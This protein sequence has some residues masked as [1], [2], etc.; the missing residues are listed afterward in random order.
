[1]L[2]K[3]FKFSINLILISIFSFGVLV[4]ISLLP[5]TGNLK[6]LTVMSGSMEP[7]IHVGSLVFVKPV[8]QYNIGD[9]VTRKTDDPGVTITHRI[10]SKEEVAGKSVFQTKGDANNAEDSE[11]T[12]QER[13][14]GKVFFNIPYLGFP[15]GYAKTTKGLI[16][17]IIIPAVIIVYEEIGKI[18]NELVAMRVRKKAEKE[19]PEQTTDKNNIVYPERRFVRAV[20]QPPVKK[21]K[22]V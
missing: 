8:S 12:A 22:I 20:E 4:A 5:I 6:I 11:K 18:K 13:I 14:V 7:K 19:T 21:R 1:M 16:L 15:I 3:I 2:G 17:I 9:V 10:I